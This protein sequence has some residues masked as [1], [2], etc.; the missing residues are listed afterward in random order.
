S[1]R[2]MNWSVVSR[3]SPT[4]MSLFSTG[5]ALGLLGKGIRSRIARDKGSIREAG[6]VFP[7][8]GWPVV[9]SI[10]G[11]K[12]LPVWGLMPLKSPWR[13]AFGGNNVVFVML[14]TMRKPS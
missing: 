3:Y 5:G 11:G 8:K 4:L 2:A 10:I 9:G 6:I 1:I 14:W 12:G 13:M 7:G